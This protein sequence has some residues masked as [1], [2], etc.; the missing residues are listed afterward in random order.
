MVCDLPAILP[1]H[2]PDSVLSAERATEDFGVPGAA[3][4]KDRTDYRTAYMK[5]IILDALEQT[6][7]NRNE[8][9]LLLK[10]EPENPVQPHERARDP[11]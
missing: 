5:K 7:G 6:K 4:I 3:P 10:V 11:A 9:A 1:E 2:L 8:A